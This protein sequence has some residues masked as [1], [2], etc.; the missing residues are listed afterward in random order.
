MGFSLFFSLLCFPH[1]VSNFLLFFLLRIFPMSP[2]CG[3]FSFFLFVT[4]FISLLYFT[5]F[6]SLLYF[7][8]F[9]FF[10]SLSVTPILLSLSLSSFFPF[11]PVQLCP[12]SYSFRSFIYLSIDLNLIIFPASFSFLSDLSLSFVL[13]SSCVSIPVV[14]RFFS[15]YLRI[16]MKLNS[17]LVLVALNC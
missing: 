6:I 16:S 15:F 3:R 10:T 8:V 12:Q 5:N 4:N 1:T 9:S 14:L 11:H 7:T 13:L 2:I 17:L